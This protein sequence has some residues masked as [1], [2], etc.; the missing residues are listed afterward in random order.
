ML[1]ALVKFSPIVKLVN[2]AHLFW[3]LSETFRQS[4]CIE[5]D[6]IF[7]GLVCLWL[8][9]MIDIRKGVTLD[10]GELE[11][12]FS[13]QIGNIFG[14]SRYIRSAPNLCAAAVSYEVDIL[15]EHHDPQTCQILQNLAS[16]YYQFA[17][18][19]H[20]NSWYGGI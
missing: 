2:L 19:Y 5:A 1:F 13:S 6:S 7:S 10:F 20:L 18:G 8:Y 15:W 16:K 4:I 14:Y 3:P 9:M 11:L 12:N 17:H